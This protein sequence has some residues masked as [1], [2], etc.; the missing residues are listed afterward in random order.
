MSRVLSQLAVHAARYEYLTNSSRAGTVTFKNNGQ[1][2]MTTTREYDST[3]RLKRV[4]SATASGATVYSALYTY[5]AAGRR[6]QATAAPDNTR[7]DYGYD[8]LGQVISGRKYWCVGSFVA[9][10]QFEYAFDTIGNR[11]WRLSANL[12]FQRLSTA[13]GAERDGEFNRR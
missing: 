4:A 7:W 10:Q 3:N 2:V 5:D 1:T 12:K 6:I 8:S 9:G 13:E 11:E